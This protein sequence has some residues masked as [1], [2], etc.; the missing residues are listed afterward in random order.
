MPSVGEDGFDHF[1]NSA[2]GPVLVDFWADW[3][4]PCGRATPILESL[5]EEYVGRVSFCKVN[6]DHSPRLS[7]AFGVRSLPT[8]LVLEPYGDRPGARVIGQA[9]GCKTP[10][11]YREIINNAL[12]PSK[13]LGER[14]RTF[15]GL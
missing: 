7:R 13:G 12:A 2:N 6:A 11:S 5:A 4:G 14:I 10:Q 15:L 8:V 9:I 3:C 1:L